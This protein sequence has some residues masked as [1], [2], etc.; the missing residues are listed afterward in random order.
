MTANLAPE[1]ASPAAIAISLTVLQ[2][3][4]SSLPQLF[5][6]SCFVSK[7]TEAFHSSRLG[8]LVYPVGLV[9]CQSR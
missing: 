6:F 8:L 7:K 2:R 4:N 5:R 1:Q 9:T 3:F